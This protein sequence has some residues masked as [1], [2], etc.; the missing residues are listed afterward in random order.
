MFVEFDAQWFQSYRRTVLAGDHEAI[1]W[2]LLQAYKAI[3]KASRS[4]KASQ[5][6]RKALRQAL[7]YLDEM[8]KTVELKKPSRG[9][10]NQQLR[11]SA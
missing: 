4:S 1:R 3:H 9:S 7:H 8:T 2:H 6:D 10:K 11:K 5:D